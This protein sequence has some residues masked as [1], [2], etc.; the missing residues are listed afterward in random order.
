[1]SPS[2]ANPSSRSTSPY[3]SPQ[4]E[5][6]LRNFPVPRPGRVLLYV[7]ED[8]LHIVRARLEGI[9]AAAGCA[10]EALDL[11][12]ITVPTLRVD[13]PGDRERLQHTVEQ[14]QPRLLI[15]SSACTGSTKNSGTIGRSA[16]FI[17]GRNKQPEAVT[18]GREGGLIHR[19]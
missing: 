6:C 7:A 2:T 10:L 8:A 12:V 19:G 16:R 4:A 18:Q 17:A 9:C 5:T 11:H 1:V 13:L 14:L 15:P 3:Q